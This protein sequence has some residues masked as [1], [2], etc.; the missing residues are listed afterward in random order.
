M[1]DGCF[2]EGHG[3][4]FGAVCA[5]QSDTIVSFTCWARRACRL[6]ATD[7]QSSTPTPITIRTA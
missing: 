5:H 2:F 7:V 3:V 6:G 4:A 1:G